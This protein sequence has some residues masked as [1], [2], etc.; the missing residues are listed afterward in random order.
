MDATMNALPNSL[1]EAASPA[2]DVE[3]ALGECGHPLAAHDSL[4]TRFFAATV[5]GD[6]SRKCIC[7]GEVSLAGALANY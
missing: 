5:R 4:G 6:L 7:A 1:S 2:S 3:P